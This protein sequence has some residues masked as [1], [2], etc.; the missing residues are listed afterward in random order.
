MAITGQGT[1]IYVFGSA[2]DAITGKAYVK[3]IRWVGATTA[4]H[5][6]L[7]TD[8][9]G[10]TILE[11]YADGNYFIDV[12]PYYRYFLG[13]IVSIMDSGQLYVYTNNWGDNK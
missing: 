5:H 2:A 7:V 4:G 8:T 6:L 11:S 10:N 13:I 12:H 9:A 1:G 3:H